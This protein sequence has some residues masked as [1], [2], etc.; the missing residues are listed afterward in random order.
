MRAALAFAS[1]AVLLVPADV[2]R[3]ATLL[4]RLRAIWCIGCFLSTGA[5][6]P[7]AVYMMR[8]IFACPACCLNE[9]M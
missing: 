6:A 4:R 5:L 3:L 1:L 7:P 8:G 2:R 9:Y